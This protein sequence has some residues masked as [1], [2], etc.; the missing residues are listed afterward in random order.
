MS[1]ILPKACDRS[2][3]FPITCKGMKAGASGAGFPALISGDC[4]SPPEVPAAAF[5]TKAGLS[6]DCLE[7]A[8]LL[9]PDEDASSTPPD[10]NNQLWLQYYL[11]T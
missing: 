3:Q 7:S 5:P 10:Q 9:D 8:S 6:W 2:L 11:H 1:I 4:C